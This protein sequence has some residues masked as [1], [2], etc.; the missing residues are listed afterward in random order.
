MKKMEISAEVELFFQSNLLSQAI[1]DINGKYNLPREYLA[2]L[3]LWH[4][5]NNFNCA[6][7]ENKIIADLRWEKLEAK[8]LAVDYLG[9]ILLPVAPYLN[10]DIKQEIIKKGG[11][12]EIYD[13]F[14]DN[15]D[16]WL[17]DENLKVLND[18]LEE[19]DNKI[20][21]IEEKKIL[22][23]LFQN[24]LM[25]I[26]KN[27][28]RHI[29]GS[30]MNFLLNDKKFQNE[31]LSELYKNNLWLSKN[32]IKCKKKLI[33][34]T[35][36]NWLNDFIDNYASDY[37]DHLAVANY[38]SNSENCRSLNDEE[39]KVL[40]QFLILYR[41]LRFFPKDFENLPPEKW[42]IIPPYV[43]DNSLKARIVLGPP[44][45]EEEKKITQL[46]KAKTDTDKSALEKKV[47]DEAGI[48][49][50]NKIADLK[51]LANKYPSGSLER[52]AVETEIKKLEVRS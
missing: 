49:A 44:Q 35:F 48:A 23:N 1:S 3:T 14:V 50:Q 27:P 19:Y 9:F 30:L 39:K 46:E 11:Q 43:A 51:I 33:D 13:K 4:Q 18:L 37:F 12:P 36:G 2:S 7:L 40:S 32:K 21:F 47:I 34:P 22:I 42:Y 28:D 26:L 29:N 45:T 17:E 5:D 25:Y 6:L 41:N 31:I 52:R 10:L 24:H 38:I 16:Q 8:K 20:D 15:F